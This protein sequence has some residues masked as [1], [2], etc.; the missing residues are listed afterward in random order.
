M[1]GADDIDEGNWEKLA[2][3]GV[4]RLNADDLANTARLKRL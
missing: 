2:S 3:W 4:D 1:A